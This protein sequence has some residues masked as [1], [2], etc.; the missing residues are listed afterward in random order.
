M[1][2]QELEREQKGRS[3]IGIGAAPNLMPGAATGTREEEEERDDG[4]GR[5]D[6]STNPDFAGVERV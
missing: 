1:H 6:E 4:W 5:E 3:D 2:M